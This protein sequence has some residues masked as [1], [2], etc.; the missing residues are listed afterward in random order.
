VIC[1]DIQKS[2]CGPIDEFMEEN[3]GQEKSIIQEGGRF[4]LFRNQPT[5][6]E[7]M[8]MQPRL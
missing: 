4:I 6:L 5:H 2:G 3:A 7:Y 8:L 1:A